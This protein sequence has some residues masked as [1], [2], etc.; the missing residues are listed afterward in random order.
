L[1][2]YNAGKVYVKLNFSGAEALGK[3]SK[4]KKTHVKTTYQGSN[5]PA[6]LNKYTCITN[7]LK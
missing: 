1:N 4:K 5:N 6:L 2:L 7:Q 3:L